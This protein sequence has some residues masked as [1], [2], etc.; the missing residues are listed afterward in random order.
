MNEW[1]RHVFYPLQAGATSTKLTGAEAEPLEKKK[2]AGAEPL[3]KKQ[4]ARAG[5]AKKYAAPQPW[6]NTC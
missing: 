3:E 1:E 2:G 5:A 6:F 4:G